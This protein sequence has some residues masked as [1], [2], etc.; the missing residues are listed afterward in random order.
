MS[1]PD[2]AAKEAG[3]V[4]V[5][6]NANGLQL[7]TNVDGLC[8]DQPRFFPIFKI[9]AKTNKPILLHPARTASFTGFVAEKRSR[10]EIRSPIADK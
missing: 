10:Y 3:R 7:H 2:E 1:A 4:L 8:L 5:H 6:G 9:A